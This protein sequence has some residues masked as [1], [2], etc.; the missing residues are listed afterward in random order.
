[1]ELNEAFCNEKGRKKG[2]N[3]AIIKFKTVSQ[4]SITMSLICSLDLSA[5]WI[6]AAPSDWRFL[7]FW[8]ENGGWKN[9][10]GLEIFG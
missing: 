5:D 4:I 10:V 7:N 6:T 3:K 2:H 9:K 1:M 8:G